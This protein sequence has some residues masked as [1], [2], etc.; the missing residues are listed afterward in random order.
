MT[1]SLILM[2]LDALIVIGTPYI[3]L[4]I[5]FEGAVDPKYFVRLFPYLPLIVIARLATFYFLGLY[6]RLWRYASINELVLIIQAVTVS[7]AVITSVMLWMTAGIPR[8]IYLLAWLLDIALIGGSR[9]GIRILYHTRQRQASRGVNVLIVGAGDA[10]AMIAREIQQRSYGDKR[11]IGFIDDD[12]AK[13]NQMLYGAKVL[14]TRKDI[15]QIV[16]SF[17][18]EEIIVAMPSIG[19]Q[20]MRQ[21][22]KECKKT[23]CTIKVVPGLY[24]L[25]D[26]QVS[27]NQLRNIDLEDLLR[28][29][30]VKI[31][32]EEIA[33]YLTG[34]RVLVTGAG[35]SVGSELCRQIA[36][37]GPRKLILLGKGENSI[38]EIH[39]ELT[40][41]NPNL[42]V[43]P[44]IADVR[45]ANRIN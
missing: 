1:K 9:L 43:E 33:H 12:E 3:G 20:L 39:R 17:Q 28:R 5:R 16:T 45:D 25:I 27:V 4:Y 29:D 40:A 31:D 24:E 23:N 30:P 8:T 32:L 36:R 34:K 37:L 10:G 2:V 11:I 6:N 26:G 22:M 15:V 18:V 41:R 14:G 42:A 38:Y 19:G 13:R 35:G 7:S 21:I 44:V